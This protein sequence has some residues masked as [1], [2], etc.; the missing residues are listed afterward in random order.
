MK[1]SAVAWIV[2]AAAAAAVALCGCGASGDPLHQVTGAASK[3]LA[4]QWARY[5]LTLER[6]RLFASPIMVQGGRAAYDLRTGLDY[7]FLQLKPRAGSYQTLFL[8]LGP[9]TVLLAPSPA[10]V[11]ALPPGKLWISAPLAARGSDRVLAAQV[12]GLAPVLLLDEVAWGARSVSALGGRV[13]ENVPMQEYRV[14]VTLAR[15]LS[16][17]RSARRAAIADA[18]GQELEA[19]ASGRLSILVWV[20]GPGYV[21]KIESA[22]P[23][24]GLGTA[25]FWFLSYTRP[26][27]GTGP[28][29][30]QVVSLGSLA[31]GGRSLWAIATGS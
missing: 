5:E 21:G 17:A 9:T 1:R 6:P 14:S 3:T 22:V 31:R 27:T 24:S 2:L 25:S 29:A 16:A 26:Y 8:D 15:A 11:G 7:E 13:V 23:G 20:S 19:S 4:V 10:P 12:E 18:I 30:S 28:P